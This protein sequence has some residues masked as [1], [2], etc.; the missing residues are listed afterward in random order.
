MTESA[1]VGVGLTAGSPPQIWPCLIVFLL[2]ADR[3]DPI[4][5]KWL[6]SLLH[7]LW[8]QYCALVVCCGGAAR[9][10]PPALSP[11]PIPIHSPR[12]Q[13]DW[14]LMLTVFR[15]PESLGH[16]AGRD[17]LESLDANGQS[18]AIVHHCWPVLYN[19]RRR[20]Y[21]ASDPFRAFFSFFPAALAA[22]ATVFD[23]ARVALV[24]HANVVTACELIMHGA[25]VR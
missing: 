4:L 23:T 14:P 13:A 20:P 25:Q 15:E 19:N 12:L 9:V 10:R 18:R 7:G 3:V 24:G 21:M 8:R 11:R 6:Y 5:E 1:A 17:E 22:P 2:F 16:A